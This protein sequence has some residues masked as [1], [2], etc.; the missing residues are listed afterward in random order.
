MSPSRL[1]T[2]LCVV[3]TGSALVAAGAGTLLV[4]SLIPY[5]TLKSH[6][7]AYSNHGSCEEF[8]PA[9]YRSVVLGL[10]LLACGALVVGAAVLLR[11][12]T[13]QALLDRAVTATKA[14]AVGLR[15]FLANAVS[16]RFCFAL[17]A[18]VIV[19]A[20]VQRILF[21]F[22][23]MRYDE[24]YTFLV[25]AAKPF[26]VLASYYGEPNNHV[27][28]TMMVHLS[29]QIFG[30]APWALRLPAFLA[31]VLVVPACLVAGAVLYNRA[32]G[33]LCA[34]LAS[35]SL[36]L[37]EY[38]TNARGYSLYVL[39][40]LVC[41]ILAVCVQRT[42]NRLAWCLLSVCGALGFYAIP[43]ML[44]PFGMIM[45]WLLLSCLFGHVPSPQRR[46]FLKAWMLAGFGAVVLTVGL[47]AAVFAVSGVKAVVANHYVRTLSWPTFAARMFPSLLATWQGW[48][49]GVPVPMAFVLGAGAILSLVFH[50][51]LAPSG[52][53][54]WA[55]AVVWCAVALVLH[56]VVP[57]ER[58]WLFLLP[59]YFLAASAGISLLFSAVQSRSFQTAR[60]MLVGAVAVVS[61]WPWIVAPQVNSERSIL[62]RG[63]FPDAEGVAL[64]LKAEMRPGDSV[65]AVCPA[66]YP[67]MYYFRRNDVNFR[68]L[69]DTQLPTNRLFVVV[70]KSASQTPESVIA[71]IEGLRTAPHKSAEVMAQFPNATVYRIDMETETAHPPAHARIPAAKPNF[72]PV[73]QSANPPRS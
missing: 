54:L 28:H 72:Q 31:G 69:M 30:D 2:W 8:T 6:L 68:Y 55:A 25:Y 13:V 37:I 63:V 4:T 32:T 59:V 53:P 16:S 60:W 3:L 73:C 10:R 51:R 38:S 7:D 36:P 1:G 21:L 27:L 20:V 61:I 50:R 70:D 22:Q 17:L 56:R 41:L 42:Q 48:H 46:R 66:N 34:G 44:Y 26:Y 49:T 18:A 11:R 12:R 47:Y 33:L 24:A 15:E 14:D 65:A 67:L 71:S 40:S 64:A 5:E 43:I 35:S 23:P 52:I 57:F 45:I 29:Y 62:D 9:F 19:L 39:L 58:V